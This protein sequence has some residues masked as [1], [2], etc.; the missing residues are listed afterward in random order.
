GGAFVLGHFLARYSNGAR[1]TA[2]V[3]T[4][5]GLAWIVLSAVL[6]L[7]RAASQPRLFEAYPAY[8]S[9]HYYYNQPST[10]W[11]FGTIILLLLY[12]LWI[13]SVLWA[14]WNKRS[15]QICSERYRDIVARTPELSPPTFKSPFFIV[16]AALTVVAIL[17]SLVIILPRL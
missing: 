3:L 4:I 2:G 1:I 10:G 12:L 9:P 6:G 7:V 16:P 13:G 8:S 5:I 14:L 17:F 15:S 11:G